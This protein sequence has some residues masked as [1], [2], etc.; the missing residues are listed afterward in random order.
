MNTALHLLLSLVHTQERTG[1]LLLV[2]DNTT[3]ATLAWQEGEIV[4]THAG[5]LQGQVVLDRLASPGVYLK[6]WRWFDRARKGLQTVR[7]Q[8]DLESTETWLMS[9]APV[10][11]PPGAWR[12]RSAEEGF[13]RN[14]RLQRIQRL[15][16]VMAGEEG[17]TLFRRHLVS[18]PPEADWDGFMQSIRAPVARWFGTTL[19]GELTGKS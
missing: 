19:T 11:R 2:L 9:T 6:R 7:T 17:R 18:S 4:A 12:G 8:P 3:V 5:H 13:A 10:A 16:D 1:L 14:L 15:L